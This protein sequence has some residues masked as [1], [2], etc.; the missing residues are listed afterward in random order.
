MRILVAFLLLFLVSCQ[1]TTEVRTAQLREEIARCQ[2]RMEVLEQ[3]QKLVEEMLDEALSRWDL[4]DRAVKNLEKFSKRR[5]EVVFSSPMGR[6][7]T[8]AYLS[9]Y[10]G[11]YRRAV[12][13]LS[14]F[15]ANYRDRYLN[16]QA[17]LLLAD[18]LYR[19]KKRRAAC[20]VLKSFMKDYPDSPFFCSAYYKALLLKCRVGRIGKKCGSG[21]GGRG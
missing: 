13:E 11:D 3:R 4:L 12:K 15:I 1:S 16:Q 9:W 21:G 14:L 10:R 6:A 8:K 17:K 18:S 19:L 7:Y 5:E 2:K 20:S